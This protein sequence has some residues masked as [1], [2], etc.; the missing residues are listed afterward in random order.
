MAPPSTHSVCKVAKLRA[1]RP[2]DAHA[3][4]P[5]MNKLTFR[6]CM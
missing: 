4:Q 1:L 2:S 6:H 3:H 5:I